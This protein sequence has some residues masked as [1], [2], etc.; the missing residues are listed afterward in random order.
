MKLNFLIRY[1][2]IFALGSLILS[3]NATFG[4][5][6]DDWSDGPGLPQS[7]KREVRAVWI[8]TVASLDWP[9]SFDRSEQ[10]RSLRQ[11]I[12]ETA[13]ANFN[14]IFFQVRGRADAFYRS[15]FEP[16]SSQLTGTLGEDPGWDPLQFVL[17]EARVRGIEVHAW[18]NTFFVKSG[19]KPSQ[20]RPL[21]I[22]LSNPEWVNQHGENWW[23]DPGLPQVRTYLVKVAMDIVRNYDLDGIHFDFIRYPGP[24]YPD[25]ET[26]R[27]YGKDRK[28]EE[29]RRENI[30]S[31]VRVVYDSIAIVKPRLKV[32][33]APIGVYVNIPNG[34]GWQSYHTLYQDSRQ[35]LREGKHDYLAPQV[36]WS[37]GNKPGDPDFATLAQNW[38]ENSFGRHIYIGVGAYKPEVFRQIP[39][40]VDVSR[41]V[42]AAGNGFFRY[43]H[44]SRNW[45]VGGRYALPALVPS[46]PWKD[47]TPPEPPTDLRVGEMGERRFEIR[48]RQSRTAADGERAYR[49]VIYRSPVNPVNTNNPY[50]IVGIVGA[51]DTTVVDRITRPQSI[52]YYYAVTALDRLN[53]ESV[54]ANEAVAVVSEFEKLSKRLHFRTGLAAGYPAGQRGVFLIPYEIGKKGPVWLK[55]VDQNGSMLQLLVEAYLEPGRYVTAANLTELRPGSYRIQLIAGDTTLAKQL[56]LK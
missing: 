48:W 44:I 42:G 21:H 15:R 11:M 41:S 2:L 55:V 9:K 40:L 20:S 43:E 8:T 14:T 34:A 13:R 6:D 45:D 26:Y 4:R 19:P 25:M 30:N 1:L 3:P 31:F 23:L 17:D 33:S 47:A 28:R 37:L 18:F 27:R 5:N 22:I 35:W 16:W 49:Y 56:E 24:D 46:M 7:P 53:N 32:G 54:P 51:A 36:Y 39:E 29:W 50:N 38:A 52:R 10:Q 12:D